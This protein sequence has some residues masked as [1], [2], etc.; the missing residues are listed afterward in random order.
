MSVFKPIDIVKGILS[1]NVKSRDNDGLLLA[2]FWYKELKSKSYNQC[3]LL[4]LLAR[5]KLTSAESITR[6]RRKLQEEIPELRG[7]R[8][9]ERQ[10]LAEK[11]R[12]HV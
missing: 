5:E 1:R 6:C 8:Y 4:N 10:H 11:T 2:T 9:D 3:D 7:S 12:R